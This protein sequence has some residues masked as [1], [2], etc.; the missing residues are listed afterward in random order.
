MSQSNE[1]LVNKE[2][3]RTKLKDSNFKNG[4]K[5]AFPIVLGYLPIG[6]AF[7]MLAV[8]KGLHQVL[9]QQQ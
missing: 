2:N 1:K 9:Q 4:I 7:G 6:M 5:D 3:I 8:N